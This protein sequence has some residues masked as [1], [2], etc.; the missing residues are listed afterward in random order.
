MLQKIMNCFSLKHNM[1]I[2]RKMIAGY[3]SATTKRKFG[4]IALIAALLGGNFLLGYKCWRHPFLMWVVSAVTGLAA[5]EAL[6]KALIQKEG[7]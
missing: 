6:K 3:K 2:N 4:V 1:E 7:E 5:R